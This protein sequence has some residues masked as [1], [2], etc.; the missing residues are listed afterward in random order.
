MTT[1]NN[2]VLIDYE[3]VQPEVASRLAPGF[4]GPKAATPRSCAW[5]AP[6]PMRWTSRWP[7][8]W[9][10]CVRRGQRCTSGE[11]QAFKGGEQWREE[12]LHA[13]WDG[14]CQRHL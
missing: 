13:R 4:F 3:N 14:E 8:T 1:P 7:I 9:G 12:R 10:C 11:R 6:G 2:H 5:V